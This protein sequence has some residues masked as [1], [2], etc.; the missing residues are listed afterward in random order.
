MVTEVNPVVEGQEEGVG[1]SEIS[2]NLIFKHKRC[3]LQFFYDCG[4]LTYI[5]VCR[6]WRIG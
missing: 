3:K 6:F 2:M 5:N 4:P 1:I